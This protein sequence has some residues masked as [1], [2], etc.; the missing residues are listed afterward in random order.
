[1]RSRAS[2]RKAARD[3]GARRERR[4]GAAWRGAVTDAQKLAAI[5]AILRAAVASGDARAR[6]L[7]D[8]EEV[9]RG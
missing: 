3:E 9:A 2:P 8:V 5:L 7:A 6:V 4:A 1:M